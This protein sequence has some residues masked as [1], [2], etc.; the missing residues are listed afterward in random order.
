MKCWKRQRELVKK[1]VLNS[2]GICFGRT[3]ET[4]KVDRDSQSI[5]TLESNCDMIEF[6]ADSGCSDH[7]VTSNTGM[8]NI[9]PASKKIV[10]A[11][12]QLLTLVKSDDSILFFDMTNK[13][14]NLVLQNI[15]VV[16][17]LMRLLLVFRSLKIDRVRKKCSQLYWSFL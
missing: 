16:L 12:G 14:N 6:V 5:M 4:Q 9:K 11:N 8:T 15:L 13:A 7:M 17:Q 3:I 2:D 1:I 10:V